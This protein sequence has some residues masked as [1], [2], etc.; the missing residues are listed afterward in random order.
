LTPKQWAALGVLARDAREAVRKALTLLRTLEQRKVDYGADAQSLDITIDAR[1]HV[2]QALASL[3]G[4]I[5]D[6][7]E[8]FR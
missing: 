6:I 1:N 8:L 7:E 5:E 3:G 4:N 2:M